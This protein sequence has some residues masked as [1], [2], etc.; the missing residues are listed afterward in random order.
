MSWWSN[1]GWNQTPA[2]L[3]GVGRQMLFEQP[4]AWWEG[5]IPK[6]VPPGYQ[7]YMR[8]GYQPWY[9]RYNYAVATGQVQPNVDFGQWVQGQ[10]PTR[11]F[12]GLGPRDRGEAPSKWYGALNWRV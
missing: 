2:D 9:N 4:Q 8:Q 7:A 12:L 11:E 3:S 1:L 5:L 10:S 6:N